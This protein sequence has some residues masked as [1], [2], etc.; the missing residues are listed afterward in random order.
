MAMTRKQNLQEFH[1]KLQRK[2]LQELTNKISDLKDGDILVLS[3]SIP[4]S[5]SSK[6]YKELSENVKA[7][8]EIVL[9]TRG[10]LLQDN[11]HNNLLLNLIFTN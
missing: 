5:I 6:I 11:I 7:N 1:Q 8:V 9:D 10:N 3:G 2:K 4:A